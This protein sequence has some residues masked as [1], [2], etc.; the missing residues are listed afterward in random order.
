MI[1]TEVLA[2]LSR[3]HLDIEPARSE[4]DGVWRVEIS[5]EGRKL[6]LDARAAAMLAQELRRAGGRLLATRIEIGLERA[7]RSA[8]S[9]RDGLTHVNTETLIPPATIPIAPH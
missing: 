2:R 8:V 4:S 6:L 9:E 1:P 3:Y 7:R 5:T